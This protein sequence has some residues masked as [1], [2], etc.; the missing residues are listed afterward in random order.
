[1][2][3]RRANLG[4]RFDQEIGMTDPRH[5]EEICAWIKLKGGQ[6]ATPEE[7]REFCKGHIAR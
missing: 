5:G 6:S 1:V 2:T 7:I 4:D 3:L